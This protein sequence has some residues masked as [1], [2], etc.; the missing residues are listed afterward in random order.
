MKKYGI[1]MLIALGFSSATYA[2]MTR[3]NNYANR[4]LIE[5]VKADENIAGTRYLF[6][7]WG[8][9]VIK[10]QD[11]TT[12]NVSDIR[13]DQK[14]GVLVKKGE[15]EKSEL[16][17]SEPIV[18]FRINNPENNE[19]KVFRSGFGKAGSDASKSFY[20]VLFDGG[21]PLLKKQQKTI[22]E[23]SVYNSGVVEKRFVEDKPSY[24]IVKNNVITPIKASNGGLD[25]AFPNQKNDINSY[26]KSK[27]LNL[28]NE[29]DL[30]EAVTYVNS[31]QK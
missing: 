3:V 13:F 14:D 21:I 24:Y 15:G 30:I 20:E 28:K 10:F 17:F 26:V 22:L 7:K 19:S 9:G 16:E 5:I 4:N 29:N 25:E 6:E 18:E 31:L 2:Q 11:N 12:V 27:K 23:S 8:N 1:V